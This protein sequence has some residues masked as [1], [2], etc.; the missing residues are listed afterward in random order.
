MFCLPTTMYLAAQLP[1]GALPPGPGPFGSVKLPQPVSGAPR[2]LTPDGWKAGL[3]CDV[4]NE[5]WSVQTG[6]NATSALQDA[7]DTC[8]D[9]AGGGTVLIPA[10]LTLLS[11]SLFLRSNLTFRVMA[12]ATLRGTATGSIKD[13]ASVDGGHCLRA[14]RAVHRRLQVLAACTLL[15]STTRR[16]YTRGATR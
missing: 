1:L 11:A 16:W 12:G 9:L 5:P 3:L 7:I 10:P 13:A 2:A 8:G 14:G 4:T 6:T 15:R